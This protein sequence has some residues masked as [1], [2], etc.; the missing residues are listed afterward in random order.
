MICDERVP[1]IIDEGFAYFDDKRLRVILDY[2]Y[3]I[4]NQVILFSSSNREK[5]ILDMYNYDY[6]FVQL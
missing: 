3:K 4:D 5:N 6:N 1:V 2:L